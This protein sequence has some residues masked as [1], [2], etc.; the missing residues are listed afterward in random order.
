MEDLK[1][2]G[3]LVDEL[4]SLFDVVRTFSKNIGMEFELDSVL[5]WC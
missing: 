3:S 2:C 1:L 5:Y 4:E